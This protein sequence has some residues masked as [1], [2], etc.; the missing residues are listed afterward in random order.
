MKQVHLVEFLTEDG[1]TEFVV[2]DQDPSEE[3]IFE[4]ISEVDWL[5]AELED[6]TLTWITWEIPFVHLEKKEEPIE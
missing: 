5:L 2:F 6:D 3:D 4:W 1:D